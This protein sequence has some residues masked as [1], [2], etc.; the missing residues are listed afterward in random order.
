MRDRDHSLLPGGKDVAILIV[1]IL[2]FGTS[3]PL[4]A[5]SAMGAILV[6]RS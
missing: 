5:L 1:V 3:G 4:I 6:A 2:G